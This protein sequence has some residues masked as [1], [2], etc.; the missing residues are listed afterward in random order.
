MTHVHISYHMTPLL[1]TKYHI[2]MSNVDTCQYLLSLFLPPYLVDL[3]NVGILLLLFCVPHTDIFIQL[4]NFYFTLSD[5]L[6]NPT[7]DL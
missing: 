1:C 7:C 3:P 4:S 2:V 6:S 5:T